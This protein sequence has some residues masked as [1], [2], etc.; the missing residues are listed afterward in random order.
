MRDTGALKRL[1]EYKAWANDA[2]LSAMQQ[3]DGEAPATEIAIRTLSHTLTVDRIFAAHMR[4]TGHGYDS[5]NAAHAPTLAELSEA[6]RASDRDL[7]DYVSDLDDARLAERIDFTFTDGAPGRM[8]RE[9]MAMHLII[10]G[11]LHRGQIGWIMTLEGAAVPADG[12]TGY[13]HAAEA[14]T[15]RRTPGATTSPA[16]APAQDPPPV[17]E[18]SAD[19]ATSRLQALTTRL[20]SGL[21]GDLNFGRTVK[22]DLR[23]EGFI[24]IDGVAATNENRPADLTLT[25]SI[26]DLRAIGQGRLSTMAAVTSRRLGL[27]DMGVAMSLLGQ[28]KALFARTA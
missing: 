13:L 27:S 21:G 1:F 26:D 7:I 2:A 6:I 3:L 24:L 22:F 12:F 9:E 20:Q 28:L 23:G 19:P 16:G 10:H 5:A 11:G 14:S 17:G 15:R 25:V 4:G 8:S 18:T